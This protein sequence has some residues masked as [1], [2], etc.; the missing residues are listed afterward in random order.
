MKKVNT[1][2]LIKYLNKN[3]HKNLNKYLNKNFNFIST[4]KMDD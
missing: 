1:S 4:S 2:V 3:F